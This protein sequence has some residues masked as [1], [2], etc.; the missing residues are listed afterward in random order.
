MKMPRHEVF[1]NGSRSDP[2]AREK[3]PGNSAR[4]K[5]RNKSKREQQRGIEPDARFPERGKPTHHQNCRRYS[6]RSRKNRKYQRRKGVQAARKH[7]LAPDAKSNQAHGTEGQDD[8]PLLPNRLA[9][10]RRDEM[11]NDPKTGNH[12][13]INF[14]LRKKPEQ[15]LPERGQG[16]GRDAGRLR[17]KEIC[18]RK[19]MRVEKAV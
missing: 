19:E 16:I 8:K 4:Q 9:R 17:G 14:R 12:R 1:A 15:S 7:V 5:E 13:D 18:R 3:N 6:K 10:K 11:G 2:A